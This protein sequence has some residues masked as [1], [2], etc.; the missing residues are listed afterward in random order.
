LL[1]KHYETTSPVGINTNDDQ[2]EGGIICTRGVETILH[3]TGSTT[4]LTNQLIMS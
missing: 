4:K 2:Q 3:Y 1:L